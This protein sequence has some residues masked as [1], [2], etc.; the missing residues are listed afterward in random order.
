MDIKVMGLA[1]SMLV[2]GSAC[3]EDHWVSLFNGKDLDGWVIKIAKQEVGENP[4][5]IFRVEDG[6]L[7]VSFDAF[8]TFEGRFGHIFTENAYSNYQ[9]RCE[10]RFRGEQSP[11]APGWAFRN[12]GIMIHCPDPTTMAVE[13]KFPDSAE[14]QFLGGFDDGAER[15]NGSLFTPGCKVDYQGEEIGNSVRSTY[16]APAADAWVK[17]EA[18]VKDGVIQH[19][20]NGEKVMEYSNPRFDKGGAPMTGGHIALQAESHPIQFRNIEILSLD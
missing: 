20:V 19:F 7:T 15:F 10:Y 17:A 13:Q 2:A 8:E 12:S 9:F 18:V 11:G 16:P 1:L 14:F 3:G 5:N 6:L 4:G